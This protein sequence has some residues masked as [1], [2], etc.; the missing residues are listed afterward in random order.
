MSDDQPTTPIGGDEPPPGATA[1][2]AGGAGTTQP[3]PPAAEPAD[4]R[5]R[6]LYGLGSVGIGVLALLIAYIVFVLKGSPSTGATALGA[7]ASPIAA[8]VAAYFGV[9]ASTSAAK[10]SQASAKTAQKAALDSQANAQSAHQQKTAALA[11]A[12][13]ALT[14][15]EIRG[16]GDDAESIR[17]RFPSNP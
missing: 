7:I 17:S 5:D 2:G 6:W 15:L 13:S 3:G 4:A 9:Q 8:M 1:P 11:Q 16:H 10:D 12:A 14:A